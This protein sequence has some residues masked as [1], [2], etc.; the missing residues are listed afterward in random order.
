MAECRR[1]DP[2]HVGPDCG[3]RGD[4]CALDDP[5]PTS[6]R[7]VRAGRDGATI[8]HRDCKRVP[9]KSWPWEWAE[10]R[11]DEEW[12]FKAWL[13][14]CRLCLPIHAAMQ[15]EARARADQ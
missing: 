13:K 15:D 14:P 6:T 1:I 11:D 3:C 5:R 7:L 8:H 12:V 9:A 10:G 2:D 4:A